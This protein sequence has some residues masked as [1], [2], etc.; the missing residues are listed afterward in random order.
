MP[1]YDNTNRGSLFPND[2]REKDSQP[3]ATGNA[4]VQCP[5]CQTVIPLYVSA[6]SKVTQAG[7]KWMSLA[8]T[9]RQE[10]ATSPVTGQTPQPAIQHTPAPT[11]G[12]QDDLPF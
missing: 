10:R 8:F 11:P 3:N 9:L 4:D 12:V 5:H 6:W 2:K 7:K 1:E